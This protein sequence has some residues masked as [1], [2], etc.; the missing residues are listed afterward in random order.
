MIPDEAVEAAAKAIFESESDLNK[1]DWPM[2]DIDREE[3]RKLARAALQAAEPFL[4]GARS[5]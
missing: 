3:C 1:W 4:K 5:A 2:P